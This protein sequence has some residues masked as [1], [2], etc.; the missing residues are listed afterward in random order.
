MCSKSSGYVK[1][2]GMNNTDDPSNRAVTAPGG[3]AGGEM[4]TD[5]GCEYKET[6]ASGYEG[7]GKGNMVKMSNPGTMPMQ[8]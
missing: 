1:V 5:C 7:P 6:K 2:E 3:E 4:G 8:T